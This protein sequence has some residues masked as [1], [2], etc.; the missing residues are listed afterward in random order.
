MLSMFIVRAGSQQGSSSLRLL[1][2]LLACSARRRGC[3]EE[4][5]VSRD[6]TRSDC[7]LICH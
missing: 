2:P 6:G 3:G 7:E 5:M 1:M 4:W